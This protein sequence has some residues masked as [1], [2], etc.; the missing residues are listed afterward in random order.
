M[1]YR[2]ILIA[3]D[4]SSCAQMAAQHGINLAKAIGAEIGLVSVIPPAEVVN[5]PEAG[6]VIAEPWDLHAQETKH[7]VEKIKNEFPD[8][9]LQV[10]TPYGSA[11]DEI[12]R[13]AYEFGADLI[14]LGTHGRTGFDYLLMGSV[15]EFVLNHCNIPVLIIKDPKQG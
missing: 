9:H 1:L 11:K 7:A 14:V 8:T 2:K 12:I 6:V 13:T 15:A 3:I 10:F 5:I 4:N